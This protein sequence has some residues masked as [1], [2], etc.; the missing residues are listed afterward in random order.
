MLVW[1]DLN[2]LN[3]WVKIIIE[4]WIWIVS[5]CS[6]CSF[7]WTCRKT[8]Y[9]QSIYNHNHITYYICKTQLFPTGPLLGGSHSSHKGVQPLIGRPG[10]APAPWVAPPSC[11]W[12]DHGLF[13][14]SDHGPRPWKLQRLVWLCLEQDSRYTQGEVPFLTVC[15][16]LNCFW[17]YNAGS[18][19]ITIFFVIAVE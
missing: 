18:H 15:G 12:H 17:A 11:T 13:G 3:V 5:I 4:M 2:W 16:W 9:K 7:I 19:P 1:F 14:D 8:L 10:G 6:L